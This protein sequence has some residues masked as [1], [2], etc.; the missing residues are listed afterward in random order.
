MIVSVL[1]GINPSPFSLI[2]QYFAQIPILTF[3]LL[4][5]LSEQCPCG[6]K[7]SNDRGMRV[8]GPTV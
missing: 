1:R 6:F 8:K 4:G 7:R 2:T 3:S 5:T